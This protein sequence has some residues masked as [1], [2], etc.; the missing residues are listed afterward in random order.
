MELVRPTDVQ[1]RAS[2]FPAVKSASLFTV[3]A[4]LRRSVRAHDAL[5]D[6]LPSPFS[7]QRQNEAA[8]AGA[9]PFA[10]LGARVDAVRYAAGFDAT[11]VP[12]CRDDC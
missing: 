11:T 1:K 2:Y 3:A 12:G 5:A 4:R 8:A 6:G 10:A 7:I 9:S